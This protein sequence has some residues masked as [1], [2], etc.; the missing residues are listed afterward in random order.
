MIASL[1][2]LFNL[3]NLHEKASARSS[4]VTKKQG[5]SNPVRTPPRQGA[6]DRRAP[7]WM[8]SGE[9]DGSMTTFV[10]GIPRSRSPQSH[11]GQAALQGSGAVGGEPDHADKAANGNI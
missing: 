4:K 2:E 3:G 5:T 6:R 8:R 11:D 9:F 7:A 1:T 10:S